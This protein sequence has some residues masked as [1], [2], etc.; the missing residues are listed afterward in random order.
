[1]DELYVFVKCHSMGHVCLHVRI[2]KKQTEPGQNDQTSMVSESNRG[3]THSG[4]QLSA[5]QRTVLCY[6]PVCMYV[7]SSALTC[8]LTPLP[9][10]CK[11]SPMLVSLL[12]PILSSLF[13]PS[14]SLSSLCNSHA[15]ELNWT[16]HTIT[17]EL[18]QSMS[19]FW[20]VR[21]ASNQL[22]RAS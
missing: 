2:K 11:F 8:L 16:T 21:R 15:L 14:L 12:P 13:C 4:A 3:E 7:L 9:P 22:R 19:V 5:A 17:A 10:R 1:M 20:H 18:I 6:C